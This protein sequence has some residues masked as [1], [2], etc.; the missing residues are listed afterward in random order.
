[1]LRCLLNEDGR[2]LYA[3]CRLARLKWSRR[4][5]RRLAAQPV[6]VAVEQLPARVEKVSADKLWEHLAFAHGGELD[7]CTQC[8]APRMKLQQG[9]PVLHKHAA[10]DSLAALE[11]LGL[12]LPIAPKGQRPECLDCAAVN[13]HGAIHS[14]DEPCPNYGRAKAVQEQLKNPK[15]SPLERMIEHPSLADRAE[16]AEDLSFAPASSLADFAEPTSPVRAAFESSRETYVDFNGRARIS[17][18]SWLVSNSNK[19]RK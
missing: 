19:R 3:F 13:M 6:Q 8:R 5:A 15:P 7:D 2:A 18:S 16:A 17:D 9:A 10:A 12:P 1:M 4:R 11:A 14:D